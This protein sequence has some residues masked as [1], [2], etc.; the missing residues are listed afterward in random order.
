MTDEATRNPYYPWVEGFAAALRAGAVLEVTGQ[1][2]PARREPAADAP[3]ALIFAPHPD[4]E[5]II[6]G[7][8]LRL[9]REQGVR[10]TNVAVTLGS[11]KDRRAGRWAELQAACARLGFGL[12]TPDPRGLEGI[13]PEAR[14]RNPRQWA[15][16]VAAIARILAAEQ[17]RIVFLPHDRDWNRTHI[18]THLLVTEAM[19]QLPELA[20]R[21][22][23]TEFWGAMDAPNLMVESSAADD[24]DLVAALSLHVGE[25]ARNPYHLRMPAWMID[26][27]RRGAELVGGQGQ[28]APAFAFA[29]LYRLRDWAGGGWR[30]ALE[31]G[32]SVSATDD[33]G[34]LFPVG[35][36]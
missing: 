2:P 29:T 26:N 10:V 25:V 9:M 14:E 34:R 36:A 32:V 20:C 8:P 11:Y 4:D 21:V 3:N 1:A 28:A 31:R 6:G 24:A 17:P 18:G 30:S 5:V 15:E 7:L 23:E 22:V 19:R 35:R 27:V 12:V 13:N 33:L 16:G